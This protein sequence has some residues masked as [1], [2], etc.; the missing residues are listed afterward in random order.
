MGT[1]N[2]V[3]LEKWSIV[4]LSGEQ[5]KGEVFSALITEPTGDFDLYLSQRFYYDNEY[6]PQH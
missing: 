1:R 6:I 2:T 5:W 4:V 3:L